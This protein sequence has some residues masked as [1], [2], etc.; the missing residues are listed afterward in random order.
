MQWPRL[1]FTRSASGE[2][3]RR[4]PSFRKN[5][6][7]HWL[8]IR[9][10]SLPSECQRY[11]GSGGAVGACFSSG[12]GRDASACVTWARR[13][14]N[15]SLKTLWRRLSLG[16]RPVAVGLTSILHSSTALTTAKWSWSCAADARLE[17]Y[18]PSRGSLRIRTWS[19]L[20]KLFD[21]PDRGAEVG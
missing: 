11:G 18:W 2:L 6:R 12:P 9:P 1:S 14:E 15:A 17:A 10:V 5:A 16:Q 8:P 7:L 21:S 3:D 13:R 20:H 19:E 4:F